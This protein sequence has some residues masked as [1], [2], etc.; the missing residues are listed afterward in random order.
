MSY[1]STP[2]NRHFGANFMSEGG[3]EAEILMYPKWTSFDLFQRSRTAKR[4]TQRG[5]GRQTHVTS[6]L[7]SLTFVNT[8][9]CVPN[10]L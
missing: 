2:E 8:Y 10:P 9:K 3:V 6:T 4:E 7:V 5:E 1:R